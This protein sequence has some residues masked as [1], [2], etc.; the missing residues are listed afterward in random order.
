M[1]ES[2]ENILDKCLEDIARGGAPDKILAEYRE[3][4]EYEILKDALHLALDLKNL[5][6]PPISKIPDFSLIAD[7]SK[8]S[9]V[10]R[11]IIP[12]RLITRIAAMFVAVFILLAVAVQASDDSIP[13]DL[14]YPV[15]RGY[16]KVRFSCMTGDRQRAEFKMACSNLR[17]S[18]AHE[19]V[20][21]G[22]KADVSLFSSMFDDSRYALEKALSMPEKDRDELVFLS[23]Y[24]MKKQKEGLYQIYQK[25]LDSDKSEISHYVCA[26]SKRDELMASTFGIKISTPSEK[27]CPAMFE[28]C[29]CSEGRECKVSAGEIAK[30]KKSIQSSGVITGSLPGE[31]KKFQ[32][33]PQ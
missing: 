7:Y 21:K 31:A 20:K 25:A 15:K 19:S 5:Q 18:E 12:F 32:Y 4:P 3:H 23:A 6:E 2:V 26:C 14:L 13:G 28:C 17:L 8:N 27:G 29:D 22:G 11:K 1:K 10:K 24:S 30:M 9:P 33:Y 16:E